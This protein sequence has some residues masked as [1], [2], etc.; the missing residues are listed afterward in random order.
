MLTT[1]TLGVE[2]LATS[3]GGQLRRAKEMFS[4]IEPSELV[5]HG[6]DN[7]IDQLD[8]NAE[9]ILVLESSAVVI[10]VVDPGG[11]SDYVPVHNEAYC[12]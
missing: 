6:C 1:K 3:E 10:R 4:R 7:V 5:R 2:V 8:T 9:P 12:P 11:A